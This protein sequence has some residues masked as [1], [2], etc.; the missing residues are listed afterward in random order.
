ME[1]YDIVK[2]DFNE[3][4]GLGHEL[5]WNHN[6]CYY[7]YLVELLPEGTKNCLDIGC[8]KGELSLLLSRKADKVI[9]VDLADK[10]IDHARAHSAADNIDYICGNILDMPFEDN[11][12]D[13]IVTSATA[14]HLPYG[15]LLDFAGRTLKKGGRLLVLDLAKASSPA[16]YIVWGAAILPNLLLTRLK[17]GGKRNDRRAAHAW[18][19][20][21]G[22]D[23]YMT[24]SEIKKLAAARLPG[25]RVRRKLFWRYVLTWEKR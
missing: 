5:R 17:N 18:K 2:A 6:I 15:W 24:M 11:S 3:I 20:H 8:G 19:Q 14:H 22:H 4:A 1:D 7:P 13:A 25:A 16:D 21:C 10:M 9:A 23:T 12:L